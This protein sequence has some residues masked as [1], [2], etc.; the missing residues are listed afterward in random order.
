VRVQ[1][2]EGCWDASVGI[3]TRPQGGQPKNH[4]SITDRGKRPPSSP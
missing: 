2:S 4:G 1:K 3:A